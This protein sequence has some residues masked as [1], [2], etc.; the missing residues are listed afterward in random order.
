MVR[1]PTPD[2]YAEPAKPDISTRS[3]GP[4]WWR[5]LKSWLTLAAIILIVNRPGIPG[6]SS[7]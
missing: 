2:K 4:H 6:D 3:R 5:A 7:S 1:D